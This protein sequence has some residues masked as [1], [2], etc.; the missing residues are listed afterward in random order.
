MFKKITLCFLLS[1]MACFQLLAQY[2]NVPVTGFNQDL[3]ANGTTNT[4]AEA[5]TTAVADLSSNPGPYVFVDATFGFGATT[6]GND[7]NTLPASG[8]ITSTNTTTN[9]GIEYTLQPYGTASSNSNN[10]LVLA[11]NQS[12]TLTLTT[13]TSAAT[14]YIV[15]MG[16]SGSTNYSAVINFT[17]GTSYTT[18]S[19]TAAPDWCGGAA[20][21][22]LTTTQYYRIPRTSTTCNGANCQYL[23]ELPITIPAVHHSKVISD[24]TF[25]N[26]T[27]G[28][29]LSI[30]AMGKQSVCTTPTEQAT[31]LNLTSTLTTVSGSFTPVLGSFNYLIVRYP[32]GA[33]ETVPT[34][35]TNY[36]VGQ[37]L[38]SGTVVSIG[39]TPTFTATG[40]EVANNYT[41]R[42][43]TYAGIICGGGPLYVTENPLTATTTTSSCSSMSGIVNIGPGLPNTA[44]GGFTSLTN[45]LSYINANGISGATTLSLQSGYDG[46]NTN[47][48]FPIVFSNNSCLSNSNT[49]TIRPATGVTGLEITDNISGNPLIDFNGARYITIEGNS[50]YGLTIT[51]TSTAST[52]N[53]ST[54][55]F[56]ND[57]RKVTLNNLNI[58]GSSI[59]ST[60]TLGGTI[61]LAAGVSTGNDSITISNNKISAAG[62]N[63]P[64]KAIMGSGSTTNTDI[65]NSQILISNN[66]ISDY[67][68]PATTHAGIYV[69]TGNN[70]WTITGNKM[71]QTASRTYTSGVI[72]YDIYFVNSTYGRNLQITNNTIGYANAAGTGKTI[73]LGNVGHTYYGI[74][75]TVMSSDTTTCNINNN[76]IDSMD[77]T[78]SSGSFYGIYNG[79][80]AGGNTLKFNGNNI[81]NITL[82]TTTGTF[83]G[84]NWTS[85]T[86]LYVE[87]NL[88]DNITR[89]AAG[90][91]YAIYS[92][93]SSVN[94]YVNNNTVSNITC[95]GT[96]SASTIYGIYQNTASGLKEFKNNKIFN[97]SGVG[98]STLYGI[99]VGY[100]TT[101]DIS[102]NEIYNLAS[103]GGSSAVIYGIYTGTVGTTF[104]VYKNK[105]YNISLTGS[106]AIAYGI[107]SS[108]VTI[109]AYNNIIGDLT[110]TSYTS[111]TSPY[112]SISG[113][114]IASG[115][116]NLYNNTVYIGAITSSGTNFS[117]TGL[118][119]STAANVL[120][121]NNLLVNMST[122]K[123]SG[124]AVA[125][126][127]S[128]TTLT[129]YNQASNNNAYY[130]GT[131]GTANAIFWDGTN[132]YQTLAGFQ[133]AMGTRDNVSVTVAP[134]FLSTVGSNTNYLHITPAVAT[135]LESGG[136]NLSNLFNT[137]Y[138]G[139][140]RPGPTGSVN[141]GALSFDIGADEFDG[142]T[143]FSCVLPNPGNTIA[144]ENNICANQTVVLS[145]QNNPSGTGNSFQWY[146]SVDGGA[147]FTLINAAIANTLS[148]VPTVP[149]VYKCLV[150][151][152]ATL[153]TYSNPVSINFMYNVNTT[154]AGSRCGPGTVNL[155]A[156]TSL[157]TLYWYE[158]LTATNELG[159]GLNFTTPVI[160]NTDTFYVAASSTAVPILA[161]V[162]T[163][164]ST[165]TSAPY[166]PFNGGYGAMKS[167]FIVK[168]SELTA[169]GLSAGDLTSIGIDFSSVSA[170]TTYN[171]FVIQMGHTDLSSFPNTSII[172]GLNTV[173][174][175]SN[176]I[177]ATNVNTFT[178]DNAFTWNGVDNIIIS[179]S[180]SNN[181][182]SN[183]SATVRYNGTGTDYTSLSYRKDNETAENMLNFAGAT[184]TGTSTFDRSQNRPK[185]IIN[186][187]YSCVSS[188]KPVIATVSP[189]P[190]F[191]VTENKTVCNDAITTLSVDS[192]HH[193]NYNQITWSPTAHL[194]TDAA[195]TVPYTV[196]SHAYTV[197][198]KSNVVGAESIIAIGDNTTT[199]C[200][201]RD[202]IVMQ[203]L[204]TSIDVEALIG[205]HCM[206][207]NTTI[208]VNPAITQTGFSYQWQSSTD[209]NL[210]EDISGAQS[211][212][213]LTPSISNTTYYRIVVKNSD[214]VN[215]IESV[216]DTVY[217][218]NP[219]PIVVNAQ[220]C[221]P[222]SVVLQANGSAD[223][224][225]S[226]FDSPTSTTV[227]NTGNSFTTPDL[228]T[229]THYYVE[230]TIIG[231]IADGYIGI[232]SSI[233]QSGSSLYEGVSPF[234]YHYGNYKHQMLVTAD[235]LN[236]AGINAGPIYS[237]AFDVASLGSS[238]AVFNNF[239]VTIISTT[240]NAMTS[241]F[242]T[243]G[244]EVF[245]P[246][247]YTPVL[248][249]NVFTF[250]TPYIWD[251]S[252]NI[253]VQTCFN[254][255]NNGIVGNSAE[256]RYSTTSNTSHTIYRV[257]GTQNSIC[258]VA[259]GS[260]GNDAPTTNKRPDI[261]FEY[262]GIC[263][264]PRT[265]VSAFIYEY[266]TVA[267]TPNTNI[268]VCQGDGAM[269]TASGGV[270]YQW[271]NASVNIDGATNET[272]VPNTSGDYSVIAIGE[273]GCTDTSTSVPVNIRISP[274]VN[275][276]NDTIICVAGTFDI[277][278]GNQTIASTY[279][280]NDNTTDNVKSISATG[281]YSVKVSN[282]YG[283][284]TIDTISVIINPAPATHLGN[285]TLI[286]NGVNLVL[287]PG[288]SDLSHVWDNG[289]TSPTRMVNVT[290]TY[291]VT[292]TNENG[293]SS[294]DT[295]IVTTNAP[296]V[297]LG[298][299]TAVCAGTS[300]TLD[301]GNTTLSYVWDNGTTAQTRTINSTGTYYV[302]VTNENGCTATDSLHLIAYALP[303]VNLGNDTV[304]C[305]AGTVNI[306]VGDQPA[307]TS[308]LWDDN[309]STNARA[310][311]N[312]GTYYVNVTNEYGCSKQDSIF[313]AVN[314]AAIIN[315]GN[316]TSICA[317]ENLI[318]DA[319]Y[320]N[321][322][323]VWDN[324]STAQTR[325]VNASG[326]YYVTV[327]NENGCKSFDTINV[328]VNA[329]PIVNLGN[330]T[331]ICVAGTFNISAG[332]QPAGTTYLWDNNTTS[333]TR[334]VN[335]TGSYFVTVTNQYG[336]IGRDTI[337]VN[338]NPAQGV[339]LG[340]D[341]A[342]CTGV[343]L[344]LNTGYPTLNHVWDNGATTQ[345][346]TVN[347]TGT[348]FVT[349]SNSSGC[350]ATDTINIV[351][352]PLPVV[353]LGN[354]TTYCASSALILN[355]GNAG[356]TYLW[357]NGATTQ[358]I[359]VNTSGIYSVQVKNANQCIATDN[360]NVVMH[361]FPTVNLG[362]DTAICSGASLTLNAG[363]AGSTYLW[364]NS[365]TSQTRTVS[366]ASTYY[367]K[368]TNANGC[369]TTDT[370]HLV[371]NPLPLFDL[372]IDT[373]FCASE[374]YTL[375][376]GNVGSF[377]LW[378]NGSTT[379]TLDVTTTG[380]YGVLVT[381]TNMCSYYD[382]VD[383]VI[384]DLP[385]IHLG[386][387]TSICHSIPLIL[388][389]EN[390][391]ST[392]SWSTGDNAQTITVDDEGQYYV[393]V[394]T[395]NNCVSSDTIEIALNPLAYADGF[396]FIPMFNELLGRVQ[397]SPINPTNTTSYVWDFGDGNIST[398]MS[399]IHNYA[400]SGDY[401]VTM[402]LS[403]ICGDTTYTQ[404]IHVD[405][406]IGIAN[407][408][409]DKFEL[410]LY[411][412][413]TQD[414]VNI[415]INNS[416]VKMLNLEVYNLLGQKVITKI[417]NN[418]A[419]DQL[420]TY[421]LV[422]GVY[423]LRIETNAGFI[424]R[425][426][427]VIK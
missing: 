121:Q 224:T 315:I 355:A 302:T 161:T 62:T 107:Y 201:N 305:V 137:D 344:T 255:N 171:G 350:K 13:P 209:N 236:A 54:I 369:A 404:M 270:S 300:I 148:I 244:T 218:T 199:L 206:S 416:G 25:T 363:N 250:N 149:T 102:N 5:T 397:F 130:A 183:T 82:N 372:G 426:F 51:N 50:N 235:E 214:H 246:I 239:S 152:G 385:V 331:L 213:Y 120:S 332:S 108:T 349:V 123:G 267:I 101:I 164:A 409:K 427:E 212:T 283:C 76:E 257:D 229:T 146:Q 268:D 425:K 238:S 393:T 403:N 318:L 387:D 3:I 63:L 92:G 71:F 195:A 254:N 262:L 346:R 211:N 67:F 253:I 85:A 365:A 274:V 134:N 69:T 24:V 348:Y 299:D 36:T 48:T 23:Y 158:S 106:S 259:S 10:A 361:S 357:S 122:P 263:R 19:G 198:Y 68:A 422:P 316:D 340:N 306:S 389:A 80:S 335:T 223:N 151:C 243:G 114:Y 7:A 94:E 215:C 96:S 217:I 147:T 418:T 375:D 160:S 342:V 64:T 98:G 327:S 57:A 180:W 173:K 295:I 324:G 390:A 370:L 126:Y 40:L 292:A 364:N 109:N 117:T 382:E 386:N 207:G 73:Y 391:G 124:K 46:T 182:S 104:N 150:K 30:F 132:T 125:Y 136:F 261:K 304:L 142:I 166:N 153:S 37:S 395:P 34:N 91:S 353:N 115:T 281:I 308:Y 376:A 336:C 172:G 237:L 366:A 20:T 203:V 347:A 167:Q 42:I 112:L 309:T 226:W 143:S 187:L 8:T 105:I 338:F 322:T 234:A 210:F 297:N 6:C 383:I 231:G 197:Y 313:I 333:N 264:S 169:A 362:N 373:G 374:S 269:L 282:E 398:S 252:S 41:F 405:L 326:T 44:T 225:I 321:L 11:Y 419:A 400:A 163:G 413:P 22:K 178:F 384:Y 208:N 162:G 276:G 345:T 140:N 191:S 89:N 79:S 28:R 396:N 184:G 157:G 356:S 59:T 133:T 165:S 95:S 394:I 293:C 423:T 58:K 196:G 100:G 414:V 202:T 55:R 129:S 204:P 193:S 194:Y 144:S 317:G 377:Y 116:A 352:N 12:G 288:H 247:N 325:T 128:S 31:A 45:A 279:L 1:M 17:D 189:S 65:A 190:A 38:G 176:V 33:T 220:R 53:T 298:N 15:A 320:P 119:A 323:H 354:D 39:A 420:N 179:T 368:V 66:H 221:D 401:Q 170:T 232:G 159:T 328:V 93:T 185:L 78:S 86:N 110:S 277:S 351:V 205:V 287:N 421:T 248:N 192:A 334:G 291:Y 186:G 311:S 222:G 241:T 14:L 81:K 26:T 278:A 16:G 260:S 407:I 175:T 131:P 49:V 273:G 135:P 399:P 266:P 32:Q 280:W 230:G 90:T 337:A 103:T 289:A 113:I 380:T 275:L 70:H 301:A 251:G 271:R 388:D 84:I 227:I 303:T 35:G 88:V 200:S 408:G 111:S 97:L 290:G 233:S 154:T 265:Q 360:I 392:Y 181:N 379:Q 141:G 75:L 411:P 56:I 284:E 4:S 381:N 138:D 219:T 319:G 339:N 242:A 272:F 99:R 359:A 341:T 410:S 256:V 139:Q 358:T 296:F 174:N 216:S 371:V 402:T 285:D 156:T 406:T 74:Y 314:P 118:Y 2:A 228:D 343:S 43:Y 77:Y 21:Y 61:L 415:A 329:L 310:I 424:T 240:D 168:A 312:T 307:G 258:T 378:N 83:Y 177:L 60:G 47:E 9:T 155:S 286:C 72:H 52:A 18:T 367:V 417:G 27:S 145:L 87:N 29:I 330:D 127:R 249:W 294:S 412:N 188:R 245:G